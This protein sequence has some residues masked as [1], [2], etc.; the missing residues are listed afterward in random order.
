MLHIYFKTEMEKQTK[1]HWLIEPTLFHC[2]VGE[3][4]VFGSCS[5]LRSSGLLVGWSPEGD[6]EGLLASV[7]GTSFWLPAGIF[8]G[9]LSE[10]LIWQ[11]GDTQ[12]AEAFLSVWWGDSQKRFNKG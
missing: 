4:W 11:S 12:I 5:A 2:L 6:S 10:L 8:F 9:W 1:K 7:L 3:V